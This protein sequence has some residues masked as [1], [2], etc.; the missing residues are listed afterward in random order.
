MFLLATFCEELLAV[1]MHHCQNN[2][3]N[4]S[5]LYLE[6]IIIKIFW[7]EKWK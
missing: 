3:I 1:V 5:I 2:S 6:K 4:I 7:Y